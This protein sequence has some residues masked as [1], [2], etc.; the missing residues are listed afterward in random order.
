M[1]AESRPLERQSYSVAPT[2]SLVAAVWNLVPAHGLL[3]RRGLGGEGGLTLIMLAWTVH[4]A[5]EP[6]TI[7]SDAPITTSLYTAGFPSVFGIRKR[8]K[9]SNRRF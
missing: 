7:P 3:P 8:K 1:S 9:K 6:K 4:V 5:Y 2:W